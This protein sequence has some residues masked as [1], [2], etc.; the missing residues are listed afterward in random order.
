MNLLILAKGEVRDE[1][2]SRARM[3]EGYKPSVYVFIGKSKLAEINPEISEILDGAYLTNARF[4]GR[5]DQLDSDLE[6]GELHVP[7]WD[8]HFLKLIEGRM[9]YFA[10][11]PLQHMHFSNGLD[12]LFF[13]MIVFSPLLGLV[14]LFL[15]IYR[16]T[17]MELDVSPESRKIL[18]YVLPPTITIFVAFLPGIFAA[19]AM[20]SLFFL[21]A[22]FALYL[23]LKVVGMIFRAE[24]ESKER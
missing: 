1:E 18:S 11:T 13:S 22:G 14:A 21:G 6:A 20:F 5:T 3:W 7:G 19:M 24:V 10:I 12:V 17:R 15:V 9:I 4:S 16:V 2:L 23:A 8:E